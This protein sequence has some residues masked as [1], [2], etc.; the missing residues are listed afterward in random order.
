MQPYNAEFERHMQ[1]RLPKGKTLFGDSSLADCYEIGSALD[2]VRW[3]REAG[4]F[5]LEGTDLKNF[6]NYSDVELTL[7]C[8]MFVS[9]ISILASHFGADAMATFLPVE[10]V[11]SLSVI[12]GS[13]GVEHSGDDQSFY[14]DFNFVA[15]QRVGGDFKVFRRGTILIPLSRQTGI[16]TYSRTG[17]D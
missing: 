4:R 13:I 8:A 5:Y 14:I 7:A 17:Q 11:F 1:E 9:D 16:L 6:E 3:I 12:R 2:F 15:K 10:Q